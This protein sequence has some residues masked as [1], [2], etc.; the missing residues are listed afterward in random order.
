M[1][2]E[3]NSDH[4]IKSDSETLGFRP[5]HDWIRVTLGK[6]FHFPYLS[7]LMCK[8]SIRTGGHRA[9]MQ[10][11]VWEESVLGGDSTRSVNGTIMSLPTSKKGKAPGTAG[12]EAIP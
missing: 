5:T 11:V 4:N 9:V 12:G 8:M 2:W 6:L 7:F 3:S 1:G 10:S